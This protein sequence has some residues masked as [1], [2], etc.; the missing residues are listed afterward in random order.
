MFRDIKTSRI[1][2]QIFRL[3]PLF[4]FGTVNR[5]FCDVYVNYECENG[6]FGFNS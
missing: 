1:D 6:I 2:L 3:G 4:L 5:D